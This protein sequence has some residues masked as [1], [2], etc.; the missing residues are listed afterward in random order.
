MIRI[1]AGLSFVDSWN[2]M[3]GRDVNVKIKDG[4]TGPNKAL[5]FNHEKY[6]VE[7]SKANERYLLE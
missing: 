4:V 7:V 6:S 2:N 5:K 1:V 3:C